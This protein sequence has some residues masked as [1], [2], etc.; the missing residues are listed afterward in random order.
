M[1]RSELKHAGSGKSGCPRIA[2][3]FGMS[4]FPAQQR[5]DIAAAPLAANSATINARAVCPDSRN[6]LG[7]ALPKKSRT[8]AVAGNGDS[9][10]FMGKAAYTRISEAR[11][12]KPNFLARD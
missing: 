7:L 5:P 1:N 2:S 4:C 9:I 12:K 11:A 6:L 10:G 3:A 8:K